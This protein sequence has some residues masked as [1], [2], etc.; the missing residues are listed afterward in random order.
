MLVAEADESEEPRALVYVEHAIQNARELDDGQR[1]VVSKRLQFV[2]LTQDWEPRIA[3]Y[4]PYLDYRP[5]EPDELQLVQE[6]VEEEWLARGLRKRGSTM[7]SRMPFR[8]TRGGQR[9]DRGTGR[10]DEGGSAPTPY[11]GDPALGQPR[12]RA[13]ATRTRR[14]AASHELRPRPPAGRR[15]GGTS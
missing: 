2:E 12:Q 3:G 6:L 11:T 9:P 1:Q 5:I 4:A 7:R 13:E 14:Q 8:S 10:L 15:P